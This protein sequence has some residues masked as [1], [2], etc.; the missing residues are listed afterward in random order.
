MGRLFLQSTKPD[1]KR[2]PIKKNTILELKENCEV[3]PSVAADIQHQY[4]VFNMFH[5]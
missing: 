3:V 5:W 2:E 1:V 4:I